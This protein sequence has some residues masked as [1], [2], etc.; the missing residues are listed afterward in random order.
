MMQLYDVWKHSRAY[1]LSDVYGRYSK[2]KENAFAKCR[3]L[4]ESYEGWG[5][6][7]V[8]ANGWQFSAGFEYTDK[9]TGVVRFAYITKEYVRVMD[10]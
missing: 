7:I 5:L 1:S 8:S 2:A 9:E 10:I 6:R 4:M 3:E